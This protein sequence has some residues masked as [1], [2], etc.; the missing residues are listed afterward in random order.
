M[1]INTMTEQQILDYLRSKSTG[2]K[3]VGTAKG[4][5]IERF[6]N[7]HNIVIRC[8]HCVSPKKKRY[9]TNNDGTPR[10]KCLNCGKYYNL[11]VNTV[12]EGT[13]YSLDEI[14]N[15]VHSVITLQSSVYMETNTVKGNINNSA[16][17]LLIRKIQSILASMRTPYLSGVI[18]VDEKYIRE[19]QKGS[20]HLIS[21]LDNKSSRKARRHAF[22]SEAGIFG[23]EFVNVLCAVDH[24]GY[25][26]A[27]CVCL[28]PMTI[29]EL[30]L[31]KEHISN[32][33]YVCSDNYDVYAEWCEKEGFKHY[34]E[35][36]TYRK[37]RKARG[38]IDTDNIYYTLTKEDY[39]NDEAINRQM[40]KKGR[41]PHIENSNHNISYDEFLAIRSKFN[42]GINR[43]NSF[44]AQLQ[45]YIIE[46][47]ANVSSVYLPDYIQSF[48]WLLNYKTFHH[49]QSFNKRD[50]ENILA[51]MCK[52]TIKN[53]HSPTLEDIK[54]KKID[55]PR[56]NKWATNLARKK[57]KNARRIVKLSP[58]DSSDMSAYEG[59]D[60]SFQYAFDKRKFFKDI[61]TI[62][63]N[64]LAKLYGVY[65]R[66]ENKAT[67]IKRM[68]AL[69]D[70]QDI[71]F[72][73]ILVSQ[74]GTVEDMKKALSK[75]PEKKKRGRPRK[76]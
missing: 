74:Y 61:G 48:V 12:F 51:E 16:A 72:H 60:D 45:K 30:D 22:R 4:I 28:G 25:Y 40:Y 32:V 34:V 7:E 68:A 47:A 59:D 65:D 27:K 62:R 53:R 10:F 18:E 35:P 11:T 58:K 55:L 56:P 39:E 2:T 43:V 1:D 46:N 38:Y 29:K 42:L 64:E 6:F 69:P 33:A 41:Y 49:I 24:S 71:I 73:E 8:P 63:L 54:N 26:W 23:P 20:K 50:A 67:R 36:S 9:G 14:I 15:A 52:F 66:N 17:W 5:T 44:H 21:F 19:A 76:K 75:L 57:I 70:A 31:L 37:E 3:T 13:A